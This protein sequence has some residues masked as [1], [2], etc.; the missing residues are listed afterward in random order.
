MIKRKLQAVIEKNLFKGKAIIVVG[1]RQVG[2]STLLQQILDNS[3]AKA[4]VFEI[5]TSLKSTNLSRISTP[6]S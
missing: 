5:A 1:A 3:Q 6:R 2:K 4:I